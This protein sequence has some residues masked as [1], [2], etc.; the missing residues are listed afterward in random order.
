MPDAT[1]PDLV[2]ALR[3]ELRAAQPD[4]G[5]GGPAA[6]RALHSLH[7]AAAAAG[8]EGLRAALRAAQAAA[9]TAAPDALRDELRL[10]GL[11]TDAPTSPEPPATVRVDVRKLDALLAL[12][13][14]LTSA[15]LQLN[16]RLGRARS[17]ER[18]AWRAVRAA[19]QTL[20][21]LTDD[22]AREVLAA[23]LE[24]ARPFLQSFERAARDA[25]RQAGKRARLHVDA[26][27]AELDRHAMDRLRSPLLHLIRNAVDHGIDPPGA[28]AARGA[29]DT[30]T[31]TLSAFSAAGQVTVTV[32]DD[33]P[34]VN[35]AE[36]ARAAGR[37]HDPGDP[38]AEAELTEL[39][40]TPGFSSRQEV[41]DLS[42]RGVGLDVVRTQA[43][44]LGG[45]VTLRSGPQGTTVTVQFPLTLATT[46]VAVVRVAGQLL[47]VPVR[48]V[49]RAG[50]ARVQ[51]HEGRPAVRIGERVVPAASLAAALNLGPARDGAYLLVRQGEASLALLVDALIGEE[52]LVIKPLAFPLA[53][54]PHLEGAAQLPDGQIVPVLNVRALRPAATS[55]VPDAPLRAPRVLLA[56]DTAVTRQL[57]RGIL[58]GAGFDVTA[59]EN[60]ALAW[61]AAQ[62]AAPDLLLTDVEMPQLGGLDLTRQVRAHPQLQHLPVVLLTSLGH[63]EDRERGAEAGADAYLVKGDFDEAA[64]V[65]TLRRLL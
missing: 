48:W 47:G 50:R 7:A 56:E 12:A 40:F 4:L 62:R 60:G 34:G 33:G 35:Y 23:R 64:L 39:L 10:L 18:G 52:E 14:E 3:A 15:R 2:S 25:A 38:A 45:D 16:E 6:A 37:P 31:V 63:P 41:T 26:A 30:G 11:L 46:R 53:G 32:R 29:D 42:G 22:L 24:P 9:A 1:A 44:A 20:A 36:V 8:D 43:R 51:L 49:D 59:V 27:D 61:E 28:R 65:A 58:T 5:A 19:Q 21:T 13:G 17:G 55:R 54:A 57:L